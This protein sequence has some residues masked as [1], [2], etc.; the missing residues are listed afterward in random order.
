MKNKNYKKLKTIPTLKERWRYIFF[1][2]DTSNIVTFEEIKNAIEDSLL[3]WMGTEKYAKAKPKII[4]NL[5]SGKTGVIRCLYKYVNDVKISLALIAQIGDS[6][7]IFK[8]LLVSGTI[9]SGSKK[10][11][12]LN[13]N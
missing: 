6:H 11:K 1:S 7:V 8:T 5:W 3:N 13:K 2:I 4:K 10:I 12:N 9:K